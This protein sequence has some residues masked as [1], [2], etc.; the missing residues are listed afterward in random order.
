MAEQIPF[1]DKDNEKGLNKAPEKDGKLISLC[2]FTEIEI[3][4]LQIFARVL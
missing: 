3:I 2:V 4:S 1:A